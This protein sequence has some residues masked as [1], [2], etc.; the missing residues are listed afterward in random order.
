LFRL[1]RS[2]EDGHY[3]LP[4]SLTGA[5]GMVVSGD[6]DTKIIL[7]DSLLTAVDKLSYR[8]LDTF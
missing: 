8:L 4:G 5:T 3:G 6:S 1:R 7:I 2:S